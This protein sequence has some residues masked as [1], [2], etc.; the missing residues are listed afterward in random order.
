MKRVIAC[1]D[2]SPCIHALVEAAAW[3]AKN[4]GRELVLLQVLD[5]YPSNYYLGEVSGGIGFESNATLLKEL[6][7][8]EHKQG[9]AA[10]SHSDQ[11]I[12]KIS[13]TLQEKH[14]IIPTIIQEK[15]YFLESCLKL[16]TDDDIVILGRLGT[17]SAEGHKI[18]GSN[19]ENLIR[20]AHCTVMTIGE[21]FK[22]PKRFIFAYEHSPA[23]IKMTKRIA[24]SDL[25]SLLECHLLYIG[26]HPE[27]LETPAKYL[28]EAGL[29][30][31]PATRY[32]D[33]SQNLSTYQL[34]NDIEL[35][36]IGAFNHNKIY[37]FFLGS[38]TTNI[39]R[40][41]AIPILVAK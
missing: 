19:V 26:E 5:Y 35:L 24:K 8:I 22:P 38:T 20:K 10:R 32:G 39:F 34:E 14:R 27:V 25:F 2:S 16:L 41:I 13:T 15:G 23:C 37:Q 28:K 11:F 6:G 18:L 4:T 17:K 1:I 33:V 12:R 30:V 36:V 7:A 21:T 29:D 9:D 3:V 31:V 40:N